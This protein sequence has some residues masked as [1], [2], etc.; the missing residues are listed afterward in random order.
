MLSKKKITKSALFQR[1]LPT[2]KTEESENTIANVSNL[3]TGT[4][5]IDNI[6]L[7]Q[8]YL[9]VYNDNIIYGKLNL[10][11][12]AAILFSN[13]SMQTIAYTDAKDT[14]LFE[15]ENKITQLFGNDTNFTNYNIANN[16]YK[17]DNTIF[18]NQNRQRIL[19]LENLNIAQ[20]F[21]DVNNTITNLNGNDILYDATNSITQKINSVVDDLNAIDL[22]PYQLSLTE[23]NKLSS[24]LILVGNETLTSYKNNNNAA[25][26][27]IND[28]IDA[29]NLR[30]TNLNVGQYQLIINSNNKLSGD[31]VLYDSNTSINTKLNLTNSRIDGINLNPYQLSL[32]ESNKLSSNLVQLGSETL[33][34]FKNNLMNNTIDT[35]NDEIDATN[36]RIDNLNLSQ[37]QTVINQNNKI[38]GS[39]VIYNETYNIKEKI[40]NVQS[41]IPNYDLS[42][43]QTTLSAS[44]KLSSD[45]IQMSGNQNLTQYKSAIAQTLSDV[46]NS[47][48]QKQSNLNSNNLLNPSYVSYNDDTLKNKLDN[49]FS[50]IQSV[51][52]FNSN[53][54]NLDVLKDIN[55][56]NISDLVQSKMNV[57]DVN[58]K[59]NGNFVQTTY[60]VNNENL[61]DALTQ[62]KNNVQSLDNNKSNLSFVNTQLNL[63]QNTIDSSNL[64]NA[65]LVSNEGT[66]LSS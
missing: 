46:D 9:N 53:I 47:L 3:K 8:N 16:Q 42:G 54:S 57:I 44:N 15:H 56:D 51:E 5:T 1:Q 19:D 28:D 10:G 60:S 12:D 34:E 65:S 4:E 62:I 40:D 36:L 49:A 31:V 27:T 63:K 66:L 23:S 32:T 25:I 11:L 55:F 41:L 20:N 61:N 50:R 52:T 21:I 58:N 17:T 6:T 30:I 38:D 45:F 7:S 13:G 18:T 33:T 35:I 26:E 22:S 37:Y 59:L 39:N 24:N 29:T 2:T 43:F 64:I 48:N 14:L